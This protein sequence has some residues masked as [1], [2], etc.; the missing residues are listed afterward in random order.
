MEAEQDKVIYLKLLLKRI[1]NLD[2]SISVC[3][4]E[5]S[6]RFAV[7]DDN[8]ERKPWRPQRPAWYGPGPYNTVGLARM[9]F[10]SALYPWPPPH[11]FASGP[12]SGAL[13]TRW[14][15]WKS[16]HIVNIRIFFFLIFFETFFFYLI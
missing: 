4:A 8:R 9:P 7:V 13:R 2:I 3:R 6:H 1:N 5:K 16:T 14:R 12:G 11:S 15:Q 10:P